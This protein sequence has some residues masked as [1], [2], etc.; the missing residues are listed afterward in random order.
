MGLIKTRSIVFVPGLGADPERSWKSSRTDFNW[1]SDKEGIV[2]DFP[3]AR[4]LLYM[5]ESAWTGPLKVKQ[6]LR[7]LAWTLLEGLHEKREV[8]NNHWPKD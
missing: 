8:R 5:Y 6:F 1:A 3:N 4:V 2:R 7:N